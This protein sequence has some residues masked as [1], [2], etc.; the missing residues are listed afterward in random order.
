MRERLNSNPRVQ[1]AVLG[2]FGAIFAVVL[3]TTMGGGGE[4]APPP[5][6]TAA[7]TPAAETPPPETPAPETPAPAGESAAGAAAAPD[8]DPAPESSEPVPATPAEPGETS[9]LLPTKGLPQDLLIAYA[10]NK[11]IVLLVIDPK[12]FSDREVKSY[13]ERLRNR[14]DVEVFIVEAK[15]IAR[16]SRITQGVSVSRVPALVV[17]RPR[18]RTGNV[19]VASVSYGF[20]SPKSVNQAVED[21]LYQGGQVPSHPG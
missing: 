21:A 2:V 1:M 9:A 13:T 12:G 18:D 8:A 5:P 15:H 20:R 3:L 11:A 14:G 19:P 17:I 7:E 4:P 6:E 16:Y 10:K